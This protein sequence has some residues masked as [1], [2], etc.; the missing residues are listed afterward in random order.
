MDVISLRQVRDIGSDEM[1]LWKHSLCIRESVN[2]NLLD[3]EQRRSR[4][5]AAFCTE[6]T[7]HPLSCSELSNN[8]TALLKFVQ[9]RLTVWGHSR[10]IDVYFCLWIYAKRR[11]YIRRNFIPQTSF[12]KAIRTRHDLYTQSMT[13]QLQQPLKLSRASTLC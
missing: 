11:L 13:F 9:T 8:Q 7:L 1:N 12:M 3:N 5:C 4:E 10:L 6:S 2:N